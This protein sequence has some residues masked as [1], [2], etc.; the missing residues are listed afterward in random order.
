MAASY[1]A[2]WI[3]PVMSLVIV[4]SFHGFDS[5]GLG[6]MK[7]SNCKDFRVCFL[8]GWDKSPYP[9]KMGF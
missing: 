6:I 1:D 9:L 4:F 3:K 7:P 5:D 8:R 2:V